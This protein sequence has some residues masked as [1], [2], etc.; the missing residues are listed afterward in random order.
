VTTIIAEIGVNWDGDFG[1]AEKLVKGAKNAGCNLVKFQSFNKEI[2]EKHP[3]WKR[4]MKSTISEENIEEITKICNKNQI[5]FLCTPMYTN[6]VDLLNPYV[7][8]F[9]IREFDGRDILNGENFKLFQKIQKTNKEIII[10][11]NTNPKKMKKIFNNIKWLYCVPKYPC[12]LEEI[13]FSELENFDGYSNHC[14]NII[15]PLTASILG[16]E[17]IEVHITLDRTGNFIDNHVSFDLDEL[18]NLVSQ[19]KDAEMIQR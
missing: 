19:I 11:T 17:I 8:R 16:A 12:K 2:V 9:K 1:I 18:V 3:E 13:D 7:K 4:L 5:E 14:P 10:S 6:A 15:A